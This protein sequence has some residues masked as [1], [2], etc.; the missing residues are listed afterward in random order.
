VSALPLFGHCRG[1]TNRQY[2]SIPTTDSPNCER[3]TAARKYGVE[4]RRRSDGRWFKSSEPRRAANLVKRYKHV[5]VRT[6]DAAGL[7]EARY[8][9]ARW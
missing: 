1:P 9:Y 2:I 8:A 4:V 5:G 6:A 7:S 3:A